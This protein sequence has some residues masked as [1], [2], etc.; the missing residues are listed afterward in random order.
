MT[1]AHAGSSGHFS[2]WIARV[3]DLAVIVVFYNSRASLVSC[4]LPVYAHS[5]DA[6]F[7]A[8]QPGR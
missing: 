6:D 3:T 1:S 4:V 7:D 8:N 2:R 5:R